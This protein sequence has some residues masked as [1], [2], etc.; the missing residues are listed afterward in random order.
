MC[1]MDGWNG[2]MGESS[3]TR[4][5]GRQLRGRLVRAN[6]KSLRYRMAANL[7]RLTGSQHLTTSRVYTILHG[8]TVINGLLLKEGKETFLLVRGIHAIVSAVCT[9]LPP[10]IGIAPRSGSSCP[11]FAVF[12]TVLLLLVG[13]PVFTAMILA[14]K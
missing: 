11:I 8:S 4:C 13:L 6:L 14:V 7:T 3:A 2:F 10:L 9:S 1:W 5:I 12:R